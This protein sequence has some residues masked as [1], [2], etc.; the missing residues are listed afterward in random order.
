M[1]PG[2]DKLVD[3]SDSDEQS[4]ILA[5]KQK[6]LRLSSFISS[7]LPMCFSFF[8]FLPFPIPCKN[9]SEIEFFTSPFALLNAGFY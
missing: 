6:C 3:C 9:K 5:S 2:F 1:F 4:Y 8:F 7:V